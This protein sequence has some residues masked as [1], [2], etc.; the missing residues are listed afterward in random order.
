MFKNKIFAKYGFY[1]IKSGTNLFIPGKPYYFT[2][3]AK[4]KWTNE[5]EYR[6]ITE[7][8]YVKCFSEDSLKFYFETIEITYE[9]II[10]F[11]SCLNKLLYK[12]EIKEL[13]RLIQKHKEY[14][15]NRFTAKG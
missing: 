3:K 10:L 14:V 13:N 6:V 5:L 8:G 7:Q 9:P 15:S 11:A 4:H 2:S 12:N 1:D